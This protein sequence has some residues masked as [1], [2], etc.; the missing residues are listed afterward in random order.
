MTYLYALFNSEILAS[1][2][3]ESLWLSDWYKPQL[4]IPSPVAYNFTTGTTARVLYS[5]PPS[6]LTSRPKRCSS[7]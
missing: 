4:W 2:S 5:A 1:Q 3:A 7:S 6:S